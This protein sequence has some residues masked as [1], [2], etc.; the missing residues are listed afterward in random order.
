MA[1]GRAKEIFEM[2]EKADDGAIIFIGG[3]SEIPR[4]KST[5]LVY[6]QEI[7]KL[8]EEKRDSEIKVFITEDVKQIRGYTNKINY[9]VEQINENPNSKI[10]LG[11][12]LALREISPKNKFLDENGQLTEFSK[13]LLSRNNNNEEKAMIEWLQNQGKLENL[14]G[15]NPRE[16]AEEQLRAIKRLEDFV[17]K[18]MLDRPTIIGSVVHSWSLDALAIYLA[19]SGEVN[20]KNFEKMKG[21]MIK[22]TGMIKL[23]KKDERINLIY[24]DLEIPLVNEELKE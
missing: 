14:Q 4:T 11:F 21:T 1:K 23:S 10:V 9:L 22:E 13:K 12:P 7:K 5:A 15:P 16:V 8:A 3:C 6:G 24:G 2:I 20:L 17:K 18:Y 19:N